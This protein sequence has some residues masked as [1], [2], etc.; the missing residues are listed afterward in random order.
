MNPW[1][2]YEAEKQAWIETNPGA[3]PAEYEAAIRAILA[4]LGL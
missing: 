2:L 4:R 1:Q 3:K